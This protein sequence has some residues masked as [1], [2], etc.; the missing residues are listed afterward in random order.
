MNGV[1][2]FVVAGA[3]RGGILLAAALV[4]RL[5]M[6]RSSAAARHAVVSLGIVGQLLVFVV[7]AAM[8][9][10]VV[11]YPVSEAVEV[12]RAVNHAG[13]SALPVRAPGAGWNSSTEES[14]DSGT[15]S[16]TAFARLA[17]LA[18]S[19][20][21]GAIWL[22]Y[23]LGHLRV[24]R[25]RSRG[26]QAEEV[27]P[28]GVLDAAGH[29][30]GLRLPVDVRLSEVPVPVA[31]GIVRPAVL[32]PHTAV[33]WSPNRLR[34]VLVHEFAHVRRRDV[35]IQGLA[36]LACALFWFD[37]LVWWARSRL[38]ADA[39]EAADDAVLRAGM[40]ADHYVLELVRLMRET[41]RVP[42]PVATASIGRDLGSRVRR[43]L[44]PRPRRNEVRRRPLV[45]GAVLALAVTLLLG[46]VTPAVR[47]PGTDGTLDSIVTGCEW[48]PDGRHVNRW[49]EADGRPRWQVLWEGE[50]CEVELLADPS[51]SLAGG[52]LAPSAA[53]GRIVVRVRKNAGRDSVLLRRGEGGALDITA[54]SGLAG[55]TP[56]V[57]WLR[58]FT[59]EVALHTAFDAPRKVDELLRVGGVPAVLS[60]AEAAQGDHAAAVYLTR[61][62]ASRRLSAGEL[63]GT[64]R[65][66]ARN[67]SS[68][69]AMTELLR[70]VA[71][72]YPVG[73]P[74]PIHAAF[75]DAAATLRAQAARDA[76]G[77]LY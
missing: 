41:I 63:V 39:E 33:G 42:C 22:R 72:R 36:Q 44:D 28:H 38:R 18:W 43:V 2:G 69:V 46:A 75:E 77:R 11:P 3:A 26:R 10:L 4:I 16:G 47:G 59:D 55:D 12:E 1:M 27:L 58:A 73:D 62:V 66:A 32:L 65:V 57:T 7:P 64:L 34:M 68:D 20:V 25:L 5:A 52:I 21:G 54:S 53:G 29:A 67:V 61:L 60:H 70:A 6:R 49:T 17:L 76:V 15:N 8:P 31:C 45:A 56:L 23:L 37:P 35:C 24:R 9:R 14:D 74:G 71:S 48:T 13:A 19:G 30:A 40:R 51:A 50:G